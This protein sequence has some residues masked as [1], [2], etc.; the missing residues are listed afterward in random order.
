MTVLD[1][2][3]VALG[4][5]S[6]SIGRGG[7]SPLRLRIVIAALFLLSLLPTVAI[8]LI[9]IPSETSYDDLRAG[10]YRGLGW[11]R[12]EGDLRAAGRAEDGR[13]L[14][15]LHDPTDDTVAVTV[16]A[17][18]PLPT[19][20]TQ[21]TGRAR[22]DT[23]L[24]DT[25]QTFYADAND[26]ACPH[27]P[28]LLIALPALLGPCW[29]SGS[30]SGTRSCATNRARQCLPLLRSAPARRSAP[31]GAGRSAARTFPLARRGHARSPST[32]TAKSHSCIS[33]TSEARAT[34][35]SAGPRRRSSGVCAGR[36]A[37]ARASKPMGPGS[38]LL[39]ELESAAERDRL[40]ASVL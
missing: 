37:A 26:R 36:T 8:S 13:Y 30:A 22:N 31:A 38:D 12:L 4:Y 33:G 6:S 10:R 25:F 19:G 18:G 11:L 20:A 17:P 5:T 35:G 23:R 21:V 28:W 7:R 34:Y 29:C 32:M 3:L 1:R 9:T 14:Y 24:P 16:Y 2:V 27:D 15:T 39:I 40:A